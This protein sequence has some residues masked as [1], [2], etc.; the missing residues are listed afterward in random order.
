MMATKIYTAMVRRGADAQS[1]PGLAPHR[2]CGV[3]CRHKVDGTEA[4][5]AESET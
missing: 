2:G 1:L 4:G 3:P 5:P